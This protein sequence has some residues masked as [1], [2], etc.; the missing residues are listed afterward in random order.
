MTVRSLVLASI[1]KTDRARHRPVRADSE[2]LRQ[3]RFLCQDRQGLVHSKT[4]LINQLTACLKAYYPR[5][6]ELGK[7]SS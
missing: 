4:M 1:L 7:I 5:A 6:R 2:H 3:L